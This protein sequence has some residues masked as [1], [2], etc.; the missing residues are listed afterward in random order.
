MN[1]RKLIENYQPSNAQEEKDRQTILKWI[2]T[3]DDV[4]TRDNE[5]AHFAS[6]AFI[7]NKTRDKALMIHHNIFDSWA[8]TGGHVDGETDFLAVAL[9]EATE[10]TGIK[11]VR[12]LTGKIDLLN[13]DP[14]PGHFKNGQWVSSHVHLSVGYLCEGDDAEILT[15]QEDENSAN[16]W[17]DLDEI[18][19]K[20]KDFHLGSTYVK[21]I[22]KIKEQKL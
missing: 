16:K 19:S 22:T 7:V 9:R 6:S 17:M 4:L 3:F 18:V 1:I 12:P 5:F 21:A 13:I 11:N 14:I 20:A 10:E 15:I 2:D 8:W